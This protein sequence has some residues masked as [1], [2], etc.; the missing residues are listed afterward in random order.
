[1][2]EESDQTPTDKIENEEQDEQKEIKKEEF[3]STTEK[4]EQKESKSVEK[5][6]S[7]QNPDSPG[8]SCHVVY[9][10][11]A[12]TAA[13]LLQSCLTL[14]D[15]IDSSPRGSSVPGILQARTLEWVAIFFSNA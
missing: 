5:S 15:P 9:R 8:K 11:A 4:M 6:F 1:M 7:P 3:G 12:A 10:T 2:L 14:C 13:K